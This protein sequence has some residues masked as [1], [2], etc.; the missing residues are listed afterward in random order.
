MIIRIVKNKKVSKCSRCSKLIDTDYKVRERGNEYTKKSRFYHLTC[1]Y[2]RT[3][4]WIRDYKKELSEFH[5]NKR[6]LDRFN[7]EMLMEKL[8]GI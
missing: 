4:K 2:R 5:K 7:K 1:Y 6:K 8:E 3:I